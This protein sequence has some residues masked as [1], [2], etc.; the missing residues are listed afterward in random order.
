L[1]YATSIEDM[2][3]TSLRASWKRTRRFIVPVIAVLAAAAAFAI[4]G[5]I[6][7]G[8]G[9]IGNTA[10]SS[11]GGLVSR[12]QPAIFVEPIDAGN[13]GAV[14]DSIAVVSDGSFPAPH[15]I[16][17]RGDGDQIC[18]GAWPLTGT[19]NFYTS[20]TAG[21][22]VPLTGKPVPASSR[23]QNPGTAAPDYPGIG[24]AIETAPPGRAGCWTVTAVVI[25]YHVG[26]RHYTAT[27]VDDMTMCWSKS[28]LAALELQQQ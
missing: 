8:P 2:T 12:T 6:G 16:S 1:P 23:L 18:G 20:C 22:L 3:D 13:S 24:A 5:P 17:I 14:I 10:G 27:R 15:V 26:I 11:T 21:A 7:I 28:R 9:P 25:H 4:W 19:Q